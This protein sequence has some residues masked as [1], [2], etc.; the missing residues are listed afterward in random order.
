MD[1][2]MQATLSLAMSSVGSDPDG[3]DK[4]MT[5]AETEEF[6]KF[7]NTDRSIE[8]VHLGPEDDRDQV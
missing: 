1:K 6:M 2:L 8:T 5:P 4:A 7:N 3:W